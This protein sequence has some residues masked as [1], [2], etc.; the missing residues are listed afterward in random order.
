MR[1]SKLTSGERLRRKGQAE[2]PNKGETFIRNLIVIGASSGGY[3]A[4]EEILREL[5]PDIPAAIVIL[6]HSPL[7]SNFGL[8]DYLA[9]FTR[10]SIV[11]VL[12]SES[13]QH[14]TIFVPP[15][16]KSAGFHGG[17]IIVGEEA[18]PD[19][20]IVTINRLF[21]A[22]AQAYGERVIGVI[23]SGLLKD[24]TAGLREVHE[25]GGLTIV[26]DPAMAEFPSMPSNAMANLPVTFCLDLSD[27]GAALELLVRRGGQFE[28]GLNVALRTLR[29]RTAVLVRLAEQ[30]WH[31]PGT[32][33]FL[34]NE[35]ES[36]KRALSSIEHLVKGVPV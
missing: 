33:E 17:K 35:L 7:G 11:P 16:G 34:V 25:A 5:S 12:S 8:I 28:T 1:R 3:H 4:L 9:R 30:S 20:P 23:L 32:H 19:R 26:Q 31:N 36:L 14:Q 24:G 22:A 6:I 2:A 18:V 21:T 10:I 15:P 29:T 13:L 27:I